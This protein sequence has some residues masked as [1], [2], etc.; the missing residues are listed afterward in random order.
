MPAMPAVMRGQ[1]AGPR[2]RVPRQHRGGPRRRRGHLRRVARVQAGD[3][4]LGQHADRALGICWHRR[5]G[6]DRVARASPGRSGPRCARTA[7][8]SRPA[9]PGP[10]CSARASASSATAWSVKPASQRASA[11]RRSSLARALL[12]PAVS[13]AGALKGGRRR[14]VRAAVQAAA[15]RLLQRGRRGFVR[16]GRR[17]RQVP[18]PPVDVTVGQRRGQRAVRVPALAGGR[19]RVDRG[20]GQRMPELD[21]A[22]AAAR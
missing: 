12:P 3:G 20:P 10:R 16:A 15:A 9:A 11:A 1:E 14:G 21:R 13:R 4:G 19:G 2:R 6:Q 17:R 22:R 5:R 18:G 7:R 8:R